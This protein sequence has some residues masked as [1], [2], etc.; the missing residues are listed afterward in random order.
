MTISLGSIVQPQEEL[1]RLF[2]QLMMNLG[3]LTSYRMKTT[4]LIALGLVESHSFILN[5]KSNMKMQ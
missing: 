4:K 1:C 2:P 3:L 5:N